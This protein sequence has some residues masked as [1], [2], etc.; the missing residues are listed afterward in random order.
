[1][2]KKKVNAIKKD[3]VTFLLKLGTSFRYRTIL[4]GL[5]QIPLPKAGEPGILFLYNH[6]S[7]LDGVFAGVTFWRSHKAI[8]VVVEDHFINPNGR[9]LFRLFDMISIPNFTTGTYDWKEKKLQ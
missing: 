8:A 5:N 7:L 9:W 2:F 3:L 1:M 4:K 6:T